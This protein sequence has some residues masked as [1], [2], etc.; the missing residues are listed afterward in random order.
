[1]VEHIP[2]KVSSI[3]VVTGHRSGPIK[4]WRELYLRSEAV[5][6]YTLLTPTLILMLL[7]LGVPL[8]LLFVVSFWTQD[9]LEFTPG[10]VFD[11][12]VTFIE[13]THFQ[14]LL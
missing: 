6:G 11:N 10:F 4:W 1:M 12:Y 5:R 3:D 2:P 8:L 14:I 13:K 7:T 9:L